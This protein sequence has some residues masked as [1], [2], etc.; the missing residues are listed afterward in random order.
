MIEESAADTC[1]VA[2]Y[3]DD[4]LFIMDAEEV[5]N[6]LSIFNKYDPNIQF[7]YEFED[8][9]KLP[10]LDLEI[11]KQPDGTIKTSWYQ[12][13]SSSNTMLNFKSQHSLQQKI[14]VANGL[15][16]RVCSL[17]TTK[18]PRENLPI[19]SDILKANNYPVSLIRKLFFSYVG[20]SSKTK[21]NSN[22]NSEKDSKIYKSL[23]N[24]KGISNKIIKTI[25]SYDN[26]IKIVLKNKKTVKSLHTRVKDRCEYFR[27]SK[28][29]YA[30]PCKDCHKKYIGM[31]GKYLRTRL[32]QHRRD[33]LN[34]HRLREKLNIDLMT[35]PDEIR[36]ILRT[37]KKP[38]RKRMLDRLLRLSEKSGL[39]AHHT[40]E[41]HRLDFHQTETVQ[42]E[43]NRNK[44][45]TLE[46]LHMKLNCNMNKKDDSE[47]LKVYDGVINKLKQLRG[48]NRQQPT[49]NPSHDVI[50]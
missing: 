18:H 7:T 48:G 44:L 32:C 4:L 24:A 8:N 19:I 31:T 6:L 29:I 46:I 12:K 35:H 11:I 50:N 3:V 15:I 20:S 37:E 25:K 41:F 13:P 38:G 14:N 39:V 2:K 17:T 36:E 49:K 47:Q 30:I 23:H 26:N 9:G 45:S 22:K 10:F 34:Y 42:M 28:I 33:I 1:F 16:K 21:S 27:R 40:K 43:N 5:E